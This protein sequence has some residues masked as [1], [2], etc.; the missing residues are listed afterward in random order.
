MAVRITGAG[1]ALT[2]GIILVTAL[3]I[4]GFF[5]AKNQGEQARRDEAVKIAEENLEK[6]SDKDVALNDDDASNNENKSS[7]NGSDNGSTGTPS[8]GSNNA[9]N[10]SNDQQQTSDELPQTGPADTLV[11]L[12]GAASLTFAGATY[13]TSRRSLRDLL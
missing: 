7:E 5:W 10:A 9:N 8:N 12:I 3:I 13:V 1:V 6:E 2:V 11:A 4:G